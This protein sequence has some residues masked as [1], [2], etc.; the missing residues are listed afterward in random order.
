M[1]QERPIEMMTKYFLKGIYICS[2]SI[3]YIDPGE[4]PLNYFSKEF[5]SGLMNLTESILSL[6]HM[7]KECPIRFLNLSLSSS[8]YD[9]SY[10]TLVFKLKDCF[11]SP[12]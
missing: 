4:F 8:I 9:K 10:P 12:G 7:Y 11:K 2:V 5:P 1:T 3:P 6:Y